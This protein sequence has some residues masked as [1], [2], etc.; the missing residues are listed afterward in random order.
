MDSNSSKFVDCSEEFN[1][2]CSVFLQLRTWEEL[3][4]SNYNVN[5]IHFKGN[6]P[7]F[8]SNLNCWNVSKHLLRVETS[9]WDNSDC[10]HSF[11][12]HSSQRL[13]A[14]ALRSETDKILHNPDLDRTWE[15]YNQNKLRQ[16]GLNQW[17]TTD[18]IEYTVV[19]LFIL[20]LIFTANK[21]K[22]SIAKTILHVV[23]A[24]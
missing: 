14:C 6:Q 10:H 1:K 22:I 12:S 15:H 21:W 17:P 5:I 18:Q 16:I 3:E 24:I 2:F 8:A 23:K 11:P 20:T 19:Y 4:E 7:I 9:C 13:P